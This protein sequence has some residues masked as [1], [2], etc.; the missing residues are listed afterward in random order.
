MRFL[1]L[2]D[3]GQEDTLD[4]EI[5]SELQAPGQGTHGKKLGCFHGVPAAQTGAIPAGLG[6]VLWHQPILPA[7]P[8]TG[9]VDQA[10]HPHVLLETVALDAH[11]DQEFAE[12]GR[13]PEDG[14]PAW[15]QQQKLLAHGENPG[16]A[17]GA[18]QRVVEGARAGQRE[19]P[20]VQGPGLHGVGERKTS[21]S[22]PTWLFRPLRTR[23]VGG[24]G[25]GG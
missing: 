12:L 24:V 10:A 23:I 1:G 17:A 13:E 4:R 3:Q 6:G 2:H 19:G 15:R 5:G 18:T 22:E 25:A 9:R 8:G 7:G 14:D 20:V 21:S 16:D 11:E